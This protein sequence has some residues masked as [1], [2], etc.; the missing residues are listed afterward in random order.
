MKDGKFTEFGKAEGLAGDNVRVIYQ[1]KDDAIWIG[2]TTGL[3]RRINDT[4]KNFTTNDRLLSDVVELHSTGSRRRP[5]DCDRQRFEPPASNGAM[6]SFNMPNGLPN[7]SV[8][9]ICQDAGG[10]IWIGS[11]NGLLWY[12]WYRARSF[13][14][15]NARYGL[16]DAFV[17]AICE[18][19]EGNLWVGTYSGL[20]RFHEGRFYSVR[21]NEGLPFD[22]VNAL[23]EDRQG[24]LWVGSNE[25]LVR[26]TPK[27]FFAYTREQGLT[28]NNIMSVLQDRHGSMWIG[29]WGGGLD[30]LKDETSLLTPR[31]ICSAGPRFV[32]VRRPRWQLVD[33]IGF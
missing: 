6:D 22:K 24:D 20:N 27:K 8:R 26:L 14:A 25:G 31:R 29:T 23:F 18:D 19:A 32:S 4:F 11:N 12:N 10:R 30:Q 17:S 1:D 15:Y 21:D 13:Y 33:G 2:T 7:D 5:L 3:S 9:G 28:H 16:S